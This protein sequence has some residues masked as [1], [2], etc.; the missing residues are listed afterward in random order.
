M[1][2]QVVPLSLLTGKLRE[3]E[4]G[5]G[6]GEL[7]SG[8]KF[9]FTVTYNVTQVVPLCAEG[10]PKVWRNRWDPYRCLLCG[11]ELRGWC[12]AWTANRVILRAEQFCSLVLWQESDCSCNPALL[13]SP[14]PEENVYSLERIQGT[15][16]TDTKGQVNIPW[17]EGEGKSSACSFQQGA[18]GGC[19]RSQP[20]ADCRGKRGQKGGIFGPDV[21]E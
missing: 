1:W 21:S 4:W 11:D 20:T 16:T 15:A 5:R 3:S 17:R 18:I 8:S 12:D 14:Q 10:V 7:L 9:S 2:N 19:L 6:G 13:L